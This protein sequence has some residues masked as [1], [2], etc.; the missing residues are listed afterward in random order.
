VAVKKLVL[1]RR[2]SL[3]CWRARLLVTQDSTGPLTP[4]CA[5]EVPRSSPIRARMPA[6]TSIVESDRTGR[7]RNCIAPRPPLSFG[8]IRTSVMTVRRRTSD[9]SAQETPG[10]GFEITWDRM[11]GESHPRPS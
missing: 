2:V 6:V 7:P 5:R 9:S 10:G 1:V 11:I 4:P 3:A 8:I